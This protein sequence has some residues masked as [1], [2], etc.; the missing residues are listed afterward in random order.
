[1]AI[2]KIVVLSELRDR[3]DLH[4]GG[5]GI[6]LSLIDPLVGVSQATVVSVCLL[7]VKLRVL[8]LVDALRSHF[9][10]PQLEGLCLG[11]R[12]A[13]DEAKKLRG[14]SDIG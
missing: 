10:H 3:L 14:V 8:H 11:R 7:E 2:L 6:E 13:L 9:G 12:N 1:M 4:C 5:R